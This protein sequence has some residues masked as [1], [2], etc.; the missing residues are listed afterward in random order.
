MYIMYFSI[1][2]LHF[3]I[4]RTFKK[5]IKKVLLRP[6]GWDTRLNPLKASVNC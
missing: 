5:K 1:H 6:L 3:T 4:K 2:V